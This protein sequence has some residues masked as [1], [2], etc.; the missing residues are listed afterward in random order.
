MKR[1]CA[2]TFKVKPQT[3][4]S[5]G[6]QETKVFISLCHSKQQSIPIQ[7]FSSINTSYTV[8]IWIQLGGG[9]I[10]SNY[11]PASVH[12]TQFESELDSI[13]GGGVIESKISKAGLLFHWCKWRKIGTSFVLNIISAENGWWRLQFFF[14]H[15]CSSTEC[16]FLTRVHISVKGTHFIVITNRCPI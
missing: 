3:K 5:L 9:V 1:Q 15:V 11:K 7:P 13:R 2:W 10:E 4:T 12:H 14:F 6:K 8:W 16:N